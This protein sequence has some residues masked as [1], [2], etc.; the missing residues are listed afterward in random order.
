MRER[1][2]EIMEETSEREER[3][4]RHMRYRLQR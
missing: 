3:A 1:A 4:E 2:E